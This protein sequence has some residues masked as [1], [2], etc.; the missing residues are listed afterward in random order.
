MHTGWIKLYRT[1]LNSPLWQ[2]STAE[3]KVILITLLLMANHAERK[4]EWQ[5]KPYT[6]RPGQM[7]T[8]LNSIQ[9]NCGRHI[10]LQKIRTALKRFEN[11]GFLNKQSNKQNTLITICNWELYQ[12]REEFDNTADNNHITNISQTDNKQ[13]TPNKNDKNV[14]NEK[15]DTRS[16][17]SLSFEQQDIR[18][19]QAANTAALTAFMGHTEEMKK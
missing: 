10:S 4:W 16:F 7:I 2:N 11:M 1:L 13:I 12:N 8:S 3:Q 19:A 5:G 17:S 9:E 18:R 15:K 6:C 14:K